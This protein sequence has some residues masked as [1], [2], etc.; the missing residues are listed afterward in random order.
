LPVLGICRG[1]QLMNVALGGTLIQD[2]PS[3]AQSFVDHGPG[4]AGPFARHE[5]E[6]T[7][8]SLIPYVGARC[9]TNSS[10]HQ[11]VELLG[12][13]FTVAARAEDGKMEA[14]VDDSRRLL[15]VQWHPEGLAPDDPPMLGPFKWLADQTRE[16]HVPEQ[17]RYPGRPGEIYDAKSPVH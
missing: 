16:R 14:I 15:G 1:M 6:I 8:P 11:A 7:A 17:S 9:V 3:E 5:V 4:R 2:L 13:D 12:G 10:H